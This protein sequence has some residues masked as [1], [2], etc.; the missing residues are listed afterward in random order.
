MRMANVPGVEPLATLLRGAL[1]AQELSPARMADITGL[2]TQ[3]VSQLLNR[4][5]GYES[6][7]P[8]ADTQQKLARLPGVRLED[9]QEALIVS[10]GLK[11]PPK[12][13]Q[14]PLRR[15]MHAIIDQIADVDLP[16][17]LDVLRA[18]V[19]PREG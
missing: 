13:E 1:D 7:L 17:I 10:A 4:S 5:T 14:D 3:H 16:Q 6:K 8:D 12:V 19:K 11:P 9:I 18:F 15:A 2:S